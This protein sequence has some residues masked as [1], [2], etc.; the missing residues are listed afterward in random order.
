VRN[1]KKDSFVVGGKNYGQGSSREHAVIGPR[2]LGLR[3][4][5]AISF[6]RIH[7]Q[8]LINF[9]ILP[10]TFTRSEDYS[11]I[12]QGDILKIE[13]VR[14]AIKRKEKMIV[15]NLSKS[16]TYE[17]DHAMSARQIEMVLHGSLINV[18][19]S[20]HQHHS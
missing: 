8:N 2:Y 12:D 19:H 7:H 14:N 20:K 10:L 18:V 6:A 16:E 17:L 13:D 4:V 3:A 15:S 11:S 1:E 5:L 9:G